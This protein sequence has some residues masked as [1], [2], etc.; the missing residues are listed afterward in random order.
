MIIYK[1]SIEKN[2]ENN[3]K[4]SKIITINHD[5]FQK[6]SKY[7]K[8]NWLIYMNLLKNDILNILELTCKK[9]FWKR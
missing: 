1:K 2:N 7:S 4:K 3:D 8:M 9:N 5:E 6:S